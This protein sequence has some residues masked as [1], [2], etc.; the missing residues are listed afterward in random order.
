MKSESSVFRKTKIICTIGPATSDKKMIQA[1]AEAGMNVA[2]LN[3]SHGNHDFHRSIIRNI[4][5]LNKDVLKNPIAILL[6]TQGPEIR[7]GDLQ[8]D[9]LDLKVGETFTFHIIPGEESEEQSVF[10][11]YKDIV[12]DLKVGDPV[13]VDNGLINLVVEEINDSALKC[14]VL[15]G[16]R[17]GSRKHINLPGI[18]VNLPSITPKDHK[19]ILFG[20]EED[21]DFIALSFVRSVEDINQLKQ[22]IEENDGHAQIIAKIEDQEAVRNMKEIVEAA[23]GVMVARG[24]LGVEVPIEELPILQRAIIKECALKGKRVIV[25]T[26]LLESMIHNPSPT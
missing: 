2:R 8:V 24:D 6:D 22:I 7:T 25:A 15:D 23:D 1:L 3:M 9:H 20:L 5:S 12:K 14:K 10:V 16:G 19:D 26:H 21:V 13:T 4:K 17:L 18:R 11:N